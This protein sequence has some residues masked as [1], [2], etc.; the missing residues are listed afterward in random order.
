LGAVLILPL[1]G[2]QPTVTRHPSDHLHYTVTL[3][4]GDIGKITGVQVVL[5]STTPIPEKQPGAANQFPGN[6]QKTNDPKIWDCNIEIPNNVG[7]GEYRLNTVN[8]GTPT[9]GKSYSEDF[10]LSLVT[11]QNP[12]TFLPPSKV[13]VTEQH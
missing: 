3:T 5:R 10:H 13:T 9:L 2:Q 12:D 6:C 1:Y 4:D 11:I 7:D 8:V